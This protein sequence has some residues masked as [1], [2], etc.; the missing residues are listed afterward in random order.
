MISIDLGTMV[1]VAAGLSRRGVARVLPDRSG[2]AGTPSLVAFDGDR[3]VVGAERADAV[4]CVRAAA[5]DPSWRFGAGAGLRVEEVAA[6]I[7]G[8][9]RADA[10]RT[11]G[12]PV[13]AAVLTVPACFDAA[14]RHAV[15]QAGEI[16][17]LSGTRLVDEPTAA[18]VG[19]RQRIPPDST[20]VVYALG[21][22]SV[23]VSVLRR[24]AAGL[25]VLATAGDRDL[26]GWDWDGALTRLVLDR[27]CAAGGRR[28]D[29]AAG[30]D[31]LRTAVEAAKRALTDRPRAEVPL[32][33]RTVAV[34]R[35][36]FERATEALLARTRRLA[37]AALA[38]AGLGPAEVDTV[39]LAGGPTRMP[40]VRR[41]LADLFGRPPAPAPDPEAVAALGAVRLAGPD[42]VPVREVAAHGLGLLVREPSGAVREV[43]VLPAGT[44]LPASRTDVFSPLQADQRRLV[45]T[46]TQGAGAV[47]RHAVE[48]PAGCAGPLEVTCSY[49]LEQRAR[50]RVRHAASGRPLAD[51]PVCG[52]EPLSEAGVTAAA[53]RVAR[54]CGG[55]PDDH[56]TAG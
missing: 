35:A 29:D 37:D 10:A 14:A 49:D 8:Q 21:G 41:M 28:P 51:V 46:V 26:G 24:D 19:Q 7:L 30:E 27:V 39:L 2:R 48:L 43:L 6:V 12:R 53:D 17:G 32:A 42:P 15:R 36:E 40:M 3:A 18:A 22:G 23:D 31:R 33:G 11:L 45:L 16:A 25:A 38:A 52:P 34:T 47:Q 9:V 50:V 5:G 44:P 20:A 55:R 4:R 54:L 13:D 1:T 56:W